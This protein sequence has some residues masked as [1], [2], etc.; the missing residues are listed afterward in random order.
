MSSKDT[1]LKKKYCVFAQLQHEMRGWR[2]VALCQGHVA[3]CH[4][5]QKRAFKVKLVGE[6]VNDYSGPYREVFTDAISEVLEVFDGNKETLGVLEPSPNNVAGVGEERSLYVFGN[7]SRSDDTNFEQHDITKE[8]I[9]VWKSF[10]SAIAVSDESAQE[11]EDSIVFLGR[12]IGTACCHS[13]PVDLP[14]PLISS[15]QKMAEESIDPKKALREIDLHA[16]NQLMDTSDK[17]SHLLVSQQRILNYF[18]EGVS[19]VIPTEI[20]SLFTGAKI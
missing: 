19:G 16:S 15:W 11:V 14:L 13:I 10:S 3:K 9:S 18:V 2:G 4:G 7:T 8:E 17:V 12:L 1:S 6:G 5:G 20:F